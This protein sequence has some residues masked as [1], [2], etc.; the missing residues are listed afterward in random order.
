MLL[1]VTSMPR[2]KEAPQ[3][4]SQVMLF[5]MS[6]DESVPADSDVRL[7]GEVMDLLDWS[8]IVGSYSDDGCPAYPPQV[9]TKILAYAY[10]N[11]V[12][13]SRKIEALVENDQ[14]Y[15]WLA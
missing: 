10:S 9:M 15:V 5:G 6:V 2:F 1:E 11:G 8:G 7:V 12:R 14:R 3:H 13:S 4:P